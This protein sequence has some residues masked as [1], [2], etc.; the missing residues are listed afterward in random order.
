MKQKINFDSE[1]YDF[2][3]FFKEIKDNYPK[4]N[5]MVIEEDGCCKTIILKASNISSDDGM[6]LTDDAFVKL[7]YYGKNIGMGDLIDLCCVYVDI[8]E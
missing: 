6:K 5:Y 8:G 1:C 2:N 7:R 4:I 3:P